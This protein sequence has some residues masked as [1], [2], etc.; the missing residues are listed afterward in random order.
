MIKKE[1][2]DQDPKVQEN[3]DREINIMKML[4]NCTYSV[5]LYNVIVSYYK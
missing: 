5:R 2:I 3:L 1:Y 4:S